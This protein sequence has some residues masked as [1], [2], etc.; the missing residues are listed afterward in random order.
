MLGKAHSP[1]DW[2]EGNLRSR[3]PVQVS[4]TPPIPRYAVQYQQGWG[5]RVIRRMVVI[6]GPLG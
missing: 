3:S 2:A 5:R 6:L 1:T 4:E